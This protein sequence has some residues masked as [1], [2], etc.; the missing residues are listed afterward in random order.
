[1]PEN[2]YKTD[3]GHLTRK[4]RALHAAELWVETLVASSVMATIGGR[5]AVAPTTY[6]TRDVAPGDTGIYVKHNN[7]LPEVAGSI[8]GDWLWF[9]GG[10]KWEV[11]Y[12]LA[13]PTDAGADGWYCVV[14][15]AHAGTANQWYAGDACVNTGGW[16]IAN[17]A[18]RG[19]ALI[20]VYS[21][22]GMLTG[23]GP[24]M[25]GSVRT[26]ATATAWTQRWALGNLNGLYGVSGD[27][28]GAAFGNPGNNFLQ[29]DATN[30]IRFML[31]GNV[32]GQ[33]SPYTG[34]QTEGV[35]IGPSWNTHLFMSYLGGLYMRSGTGADVISMD[36]GGNLFLKGN[37]SS[38]TTG[39]ITFASG[40]GYF[41]GW[42]G[43]TPQM[44]IG[45][46]PSV[47]TNRRLT[48]DG[49]SLKLVS[50]GLTIDETG[51]RFAN[52][53][54]GEMSKILSWGQYGSETTYQYDDS[55]QYTLWHRYGTLKLVVNS[56]DSGSIVQ[57]KAGESG[58]FQHWLNLQPGSFVSY[59]SGPTV[60]VWHIQTTQFYVGIANSDT[61]SY[62]TG[63]KDLIGSL[64]RSDL[65]WHTYWGYYM[66]LA[67]RTAV[68][69]LLELGVDSAAKPNSTT[70]YVPSDFRLKR[71]VEPVDR[72]AALAAVRATRMVRYTYNGVNETP[73]GLRG[74][75]V[76]AEQ[77]AEVLPAS[78]M[79][80]GPEGYLAWN[81]HE[82]L[83]CNVCAVQLLAE[84]LDALEGKGK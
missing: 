73:A 49:T 37:L 84:R 15:R 74:I 29:I 30:G 1:M 28:F 21:V 59:Y 63:A 3:L 41:L 10:G 4:W 57:L 40:T 26:G 19:G 39:P 11:M 5:L 67:S 8:H 7:L 6:L 31:T 54:S 42:S 13:G 45:K 35:T 75:G 33:W 83:M 20:D 77:A 2:A 50:D 61:P 71:D 18:R 76:E 68:A 69:Y 36:T 23:Y 12:T 60:P 14:G 43:G 32:W 24:T 65:L 55:N 46:D 34:A 48:W 25:V 47:A 81:A 22:S 79:R 38:G 27:V 82:L 56:S 72:A 66:K 78:V 64:G 51:I 44:R 9:E 53:G 70:W 80:A 58:V 62:F 17:N 52:G 16:H